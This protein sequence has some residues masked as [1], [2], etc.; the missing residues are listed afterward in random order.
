MPG[1]GGQPGCKVIRYGISGNSVLNLSIAANVALGVFA[2]AR[3]V[4]ERAP[5]EGGAGGQYLVV[6]GVRYEDLVVDERVL[7]DLSGK[8]S[9]M[10]FLFGG[11]AA[12]EAWD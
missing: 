7:E 10:I 8:A 5:P 6:V 3:E 9:F 2:F 1:K 4:G 11:S 12:V